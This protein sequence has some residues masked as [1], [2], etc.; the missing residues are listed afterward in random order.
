[1]VTLGI[2]SQELE[3]A[4]VL[5]VDDNAIRFKAHAWSSRAGNAIS[6]RGQV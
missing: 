5:P 2:R 6:D 3:R 1:M 4:D